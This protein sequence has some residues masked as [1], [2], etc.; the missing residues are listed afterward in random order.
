LPA[1]G[2][3]SVVWARALP[4]ASL[5]AAL[6]ARRSQPFPLVCSL[7][8]PL[9][10]ASAGEGPGAT[11]RAV[12]RLAL[13]QVE[14][15]GGLA[16]A[17]TFP[18]RRV[19]ELVAGAAH[20][21]RA[22]CFVVPHLVPRGPV[23]HPAP[24]HPDPPVPLVV[25]AGSA[26]R[27][28]I[29]G[30]LLPALARAQAQ[31]RLR[32][33]VALRDGDAATVRRV[34]D[35]LGGG[36]VHADL[37]PAVAA[38]LL[39]RADAIVTPAPSPDLLYTKVVEAVGRAVPVLALTPAPGT[40]ADVVAAAG[41]IVVD[42]QSDTA[43]DAALG[44]LG[45][46]AGPGRSRSQDQRAETAAR[47]DPSTVTDTAEAVVAFARERFGAVRRGAAAPPAPALPSWP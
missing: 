21:E 5:A 25:Y 4:E 9:P 31:G 11:D 2:G 36:T 24:P 13:R 15:L 14:A 35:L 22:R 18:C 3:R 38:D 34:A 44:L 6:Q 23:T 39:D 17:W 1:D 28:L 32:A 20:L 27:W 41:G 37:T 40:T 47:L 16:D 8:D 33:E 29:D 26:Y 42:E 30:P 12:A 46:M 43:L 45:E 10:P 7:G 19:L